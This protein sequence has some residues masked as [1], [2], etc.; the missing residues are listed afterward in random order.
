MQQRN[1]GP[2]SLRNSNSARTKVCRDALR[3]RRSGLGALA[4]DKSCSPDGCS[5]MFL[6]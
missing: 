2:S 5:G 4:R 3:G 1:S 6:I